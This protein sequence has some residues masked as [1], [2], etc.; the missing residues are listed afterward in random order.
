MLSKQKSAQSVIPA[1]AGIQNDI[2][3]WIPA[4]GTMCLAGMTKIFITFFLLFSFLPLSLSAAQTDKTRA[5]ALYHQLRCVVCAGQSL[6]ESHADMAVQMRALVR[7]QM[8]EGM[9]D[10]EILSFFAERYGDEILTTPP[11]N[12]FTWLLWVAPLL[13][14]FFGLIL[15]R[16]SPKK[17]AP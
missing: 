10:Q 1:K 15:W 11:V 13:C 2:I 7:K 16:V 4:F 12:P 9:S 14:V 6:A 3:N 17:S 5:D 8:K